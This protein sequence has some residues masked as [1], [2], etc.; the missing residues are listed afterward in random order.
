[1]L[2]RPVTYAKE[3]IS[4]KMQVA[5]YI[6]WFSLESILFSI[7]LHNNCTSCCMF[8]CG[9]KQKSSTMAYTV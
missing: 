4:M 2:T 6:S 9:D 7:K 3:E 5:F 8:L 1:M